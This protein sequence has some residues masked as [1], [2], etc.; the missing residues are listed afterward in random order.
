MKRK[1]PTA[2][3]LTV[4]IA[5]LA[6]IALGVSGGSAKTPPSRTAAHSVLRVRSTSLGKILVDGSGRTLYLF[7]GDR[8]NLST[9]SAAGRAVWPPFTSAG[10]IKTRGG[11]QAAK[12]GTA[13]GRGGAR[14]VSYN[15]HPLYYYV[16]DSK[17]G[18]VGGQHLKEFGALWYVLGRNGGAITAAPRTNQPAP[19]APAP[20]G[21]G[22]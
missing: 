20:A 17:P 19:R 6:V 9:L 15:G 10:A 11:A 3:T 16:G 2:L 14:Q 21:Y 5:A 12:L 13:T 1:F 22:Y 8:A 18:S 4:V 7:E